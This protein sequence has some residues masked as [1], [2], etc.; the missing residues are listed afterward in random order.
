VSDFLFNS[1][2]HRGRN[3]QT[4]DHMIVQD[5][6]LLHG[7]GV[8]SGQKNS[9]RMIVPG[10]QHKGREEVIRCRCESLSRFPQKRTFVSSARAVSKPVRRVPWHT[11]ITRSDLLPSGSPRLKR[12]PSIC[13]IVVVKLSMWPDYLIPAYSNDAIKALDATVRSIT[14]RNRLRTPKIGVAQMRPVGST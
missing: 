7:D 4:P 12:L 1:G 10:K 13:R 8:I 2:A 14:D 6:K 11:V 5:A 3:V 9:G